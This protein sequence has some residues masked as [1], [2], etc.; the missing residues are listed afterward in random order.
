MI[1]YTSGRTMSTI[2]KVKRFIKDYTVPSCAKSILLNVKVNREKRNGPAKYWC[3][4]SGSHF[5]LEVFFCGM[6]DEPSKE[7]GDYCHR[8]E[9][10][11]MTSWQPYWFSKTMNV[12]SHVVVPNQSCV[13]STL[14]LCKHFLLSQ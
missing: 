7:P 2:K 11:Q 3:G 5:V 4:I 1:L 14:F 13:S 12:A 6:H 9:R 8:R 10:M